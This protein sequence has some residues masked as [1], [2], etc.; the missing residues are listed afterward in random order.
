LLVVIDEFDILRIA[1][2][3]GAGVVTELRG[4][5]Q[6]LQSSPALRDR[7]V[8]AILSVRGARE[9]F[10]Y[11]VAGPT[12][13]IELPIDVVALG[14]FR[15]TDATRRRLADSLRDVAPESAD[16]L[17][18]AVRDTTG[19]YPQLCLEILRRVREVIVA[20]REAF[21]GLGSSTVVRPAS[22]E[23]FPTPAD[24]AMFLDAQPTWYRHDADDIRRQFFSI[25]EGFIHEPEAPRI[26]ALRAY[27]GMLDAESG[28]GEPVGYDAS[29]PAHRVLEVAGLVRA[30]DGWLR[31][32]APFLAAYFDRV[33]ADRLLAR[34][35]EER[36]SAARER[37]AREPISERRLLVLVTGGTIG[38]VEREGRVSPPD[39]GDD[40]AD[41]YADVTELFPNVKWEPL[42]NLDS[43]NVGPTQWKRFSETIYDRLLERM[44]DRRTPRWEGV[45]VAHGT[46]TLSF[47]ASAVAYALGPQLDVPVVFTGSQTTVDVAY[48]D[49]RSNLLRACMVAASPQPSPANLPEVA[50]AFGESV[51]RGVRAMK[52]DD[53]RFD[54]FESPAYPLLGTI[55][56]TVQLHEHL[57]REVVP[58][59]IRLQAEFSSRI[60]VVPQVPG[61]DPE[62]Y[63]SA[64]RLPPDRRPRGVVLQSLG[65][66]NIPTSGRTSL[67]PFVRETCD[68]GIPVLLAG[69]YPVHPAN[70]G[71]YDPPYQARRAGAIP[72]AN[73]TTAALVAKFSW[74]LAS[75]GDASPDAVN[76][77][78]RQTMQA[79]LVG[80]VDERESR[81]LAD[82]ELD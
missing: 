79:N 29:D 13:G 21:L 11:D 62:F 50:V 24:L 80:E 53:R 48:G 39:D 77:T 33:W 46:D 56:E 32:Y 1:G 25:P 52:R 31:P 61:I 74:V 28:R 41:E 12:A 34:F 9:L 2:A 76:L 14:P 72:V 71:R 57:I 63:V 10:D 45:I 18:R 49:A 40:L 81:A 22:A 20:H 55:S 36:R 68:L 38:M 15:T 75:L 37:S 5:L 82:L 35:Q 4:V 23:R 42:D 73:M 7:L 67:V 70:F 16:D 66:G 44:P 47:A 54:A 51:F 30:V 19:G 60:L 43:A 17:A 65:A 78:V 6:E 27:R 26:D 8:L 3:S 69:Q 58:G 59:P 64:L